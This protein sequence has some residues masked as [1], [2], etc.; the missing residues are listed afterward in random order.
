MSQERDIIQVIDN[1]NRH[2]ILNSIDTS[3][4]IKKLINLKA[5][6]NL[7]ENYCFIIIKIIK[8]FME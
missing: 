4:I 6:L 5:L 2:E 8:I 1:F 3:D 7:K